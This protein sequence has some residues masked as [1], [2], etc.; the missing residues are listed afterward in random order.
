MM[1]GIDI[2]DVNVRWLRSQIGYV[3]QEPVL[4][5]GTISD[6]IQRGRADVVDSPLQSLQGT[7][8]SLT[9]NNMPSPHTP[10]PTHILF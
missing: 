1:D 5:S 4:F 8:M 10:L 7:S 2:R 3:G 9:T 6:N